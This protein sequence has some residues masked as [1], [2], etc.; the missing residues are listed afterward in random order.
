VLAAEFESGFDVAP[1]LVPD[2]PVDDADELPVVPES[3]APVEVAE[4]SPVVPEPDVASA[5]PLSPD[6]AP[7]YASPSGAYAKLNAD[8]VSPDP[9]L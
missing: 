9:V 4:P 8:P 3:A 6:A 2:V 1:P 7:A 5:D